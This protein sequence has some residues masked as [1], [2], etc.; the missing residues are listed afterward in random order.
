M[1]GS[2]RRNTRGW[3]SAGDT[4]PD[5]SQ[6][7]CSVLTLNTSG[8]GIAFA[9]DGGWSMPCEVAIAAAR[10]NARQPQST[11]AVATRLR[12][13]DV[14]REGADVQAFRLVGADKQRAAD[15]E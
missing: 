6:A 3:P 4:S 8:G 14:D 13:L 15:C 11:G 5:P 10:F 2:I 9:D 1:S 12:I 7:T